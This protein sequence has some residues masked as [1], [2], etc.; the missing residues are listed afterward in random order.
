MTLAWCPKSTNLLVSNNLTRKALSLRLLLLLP[1]PQDKMPPF[2]VDNTIGALLVSSLIG[3]YSCGIVAVQAAR[4][5]T[6]WNADRWEFKVVVWISLVLTF[7]NMAIWP[8]WFLHW[9]VA[10][11]GD[12]AVMVHVHFAFPV[13]LILVGLSASTVHFFFA[14]RLKVLGGPKL[15][16]WILPMFV[17][18]MST[19]QLLAMLITTVRES[20]NALMANL[21][22]IYPAGK[23]WCGAS[24]SADVTITFGMLYHLIWIPR[25]AAFDSRF[26]FR[27]IA[28]RAIEN[29]I[30]SLFLQIFLTI[31]LTR[32]PGLFFTC[33]D[34]TMAPAYTLALLLSLN[35]RNPQNLGAY[36]W[37][38]I[39][40]S[41]PS[42]RKPK[43]IRRSS[44]P[45]S[46]GVFVTVQEERRVDICEG[47]Q[48]WKNPLP[49]RADPVNIRFNE[50]STPSSSSKGGSLE[51]Q[52]V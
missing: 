26:T 10:H 12:P 35:S 36:S 50:V 32:G 20:S 8:S 42:P 27:R 38:D 14:W 30:V 41:D 16:S 2:P 6:T 17:V 21:P 28:I 49:V 45:G 18:T 9:G 29:N 40:P 52:T 46:E 25:K 4:Y 23:I 15:H 48:I 37:H 33:V 44:N 7:C 43:R 1:P 22:A 19:A 51:V 3:F 31:M 47:S 24:I 5:F 39:Q 13:A 34:T 11:A